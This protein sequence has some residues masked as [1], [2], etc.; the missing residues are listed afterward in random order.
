MSQTDHAANGVGG[1]AAADLLA[2]AS[3]EA[4]ID[5]QGNLIDE[6]AD[7]DF[8]CSHCGHPMVI[9]VR[10]AGLTVVCT[11]CGEPVQVPIPEGMEIADLDE[12]PEHMFAQI[13]HLRR[14]LS[15]AEER[16]VELERVVSSL[17][18][19]RTTL[20]R[21]RLSS[22][23]RCV[24]MGNLLHTVL[25]NHNEIIA[26]VQRIQALLAEEEK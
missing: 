3:G 19:R 6:R 24:E 13:V 12:T 4:R 16:V 9:N 17:M 25:R 26:V 5:D 18:E 21:A 10:G 14:S 20:E 22:L 23:H 8:S 11:E 2:P 7:I 1:E 15:N